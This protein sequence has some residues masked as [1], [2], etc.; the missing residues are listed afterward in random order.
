MHIKS[1]VNVEV[2]MSDGSS[3]NLGSF[4]TRSAGDMQRALDTPLPGLTGAAES[5]GA[6][7]G[8]GVV[9]AASRQDQNAQASSKGSFANG[10]VSGA[11]MAAMSG[12]S[13]E[14][15]GASSDLPADQIRTDKVRGTL[16]K[17]DLNIESGYASA[18]EAA[19][20][21][22]GAYTAD[23]T[24]AGKSK[25]VLGLT[26]LRDGRHYFSS[27]LTVP[28]QF[29]AS[30]RLD[31]IRSSEI[32]GYTHTH[33]DASGFSGLD[34]KTP[35]QTKLPY[36]VRN[37]QG[38]V[39]RWEPSGAAK[40]ARYVSGLQRGRSMQSQSTDLPDPARWGITNICSGGSP[41]VR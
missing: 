16:S 18:N 11:V 13:T 34:Y 5:N 30:I 19:I 39:Y 14:V 7:K 22:Y 21:Q 41:C 25:E 12:N 24:A 37:S 36:F 15:T 17:S 31:G 1:C 35:A 29:T 6:T 26:F 9:G 23:Y 38:N 27:V 10:A 2:E 3:K 4:N 40:Y 20:A 28:K 32:S 8:S 33:P